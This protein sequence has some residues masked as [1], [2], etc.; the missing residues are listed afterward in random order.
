VT[1]SRCD[2]DEAALADFKC[3]YRSIHRALGKRAKRPWSRDLQLAELPVRTSG[4]AGPTLRNTTALTQLM[5]GRRATNGKDFLVDRTQEVASTNLASSIRK[6][7][8][9]SGLFPSSVLSRQT[10]HAAK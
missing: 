5:F 6:K 4:N 3:E 7:R 1:S 9:P 10:P 8:S 2:F